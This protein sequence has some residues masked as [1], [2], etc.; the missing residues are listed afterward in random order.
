MS[1][2]LDEKL[3]DNARHPRIYQSHFVLTWQHQSSR[4]VN[5]LAPGVQGSRI[6][7]VLGCVISPLRQHA[8]SRKLGQTLF[9]SPVLVPSLRIFS[10]TAATP[11]NCLA[12]ITTGFLQLPTYSIVQFV[13][14]S[15]C[16]WRRSCCWW[17]NCQFVGERGRE[18]PDRGFQNI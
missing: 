8:E 7:L 15:L 12:A 3:N 5:V 13:I 18:F 2:E 11:N 10:G 9:G 4:F 14:M 17:R 16:Y 6:R 1:P